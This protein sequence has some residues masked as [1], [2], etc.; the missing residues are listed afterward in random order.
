[1]LSRKSSTRAASSDPKRP[2]S[3]MSSTDVAHALAS[4]KESRAARRI[5][6]MYRTISPQMLTRTYVAAFFKPVDGVTQ[7]YALSI[8]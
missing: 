5:Q 4:I 7:A 2:R 3:A 1:M 8:R 6:R